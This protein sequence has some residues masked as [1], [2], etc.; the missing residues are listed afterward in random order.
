MRFAFQLTLLTSFLLL[1]ACT[2]NDSAGKN[3][4]ALKEKADLFGDWKG[5]LK[6]GTT[7][8]VMFNDKL[9]VVS[10]LGPGIDREKAQKAAEFVAGN[11]GRSLNGGSF[12][13][14]SM[15]YEIDAQKNEAKIHGADAGPAVAKLSN[16]GALLLSGEFKMSNANFA[17]PETRLERVK[18]GEPK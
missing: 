2:K 1:S 7:V 14:G 6:D 9:A 16:D 18:P 8:E 17:V 5:T 3:Q 10:I 4:G 12:G 11:L 13:M 15:A